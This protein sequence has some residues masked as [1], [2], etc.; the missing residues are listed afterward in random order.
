MKNLKFKIAALAL[1]GVV[2]VQAQDL[3]MQEVP[4]NLNESFQKAYPQA[5]DVEWEK[6]GTTYKVEF[7]A[8]RMEHEIWYSENGNIVKTEKE[9]A[10]ADLPAA[11]TTALK[12]N[13]SKH[14]IDEVEMTEENGKKI[15]EVELEKMFSKDIKLF[16]LDDG[17]IVEERM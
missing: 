11:V 12:T 5:T 1:F 10:I 17:S 7:D 13:Y 6:E 14:K 2:A 3:T 15:Y 8:N 4:A 16:M 9:L